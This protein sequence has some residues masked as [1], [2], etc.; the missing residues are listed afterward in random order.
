MRWLYLFEAVCGLIAIYFALPFVTVIIM[1]LTGSCHELHE[2]YYYQVA[3][4]E[5]IISVSSIFKSDSRNVMVNITSRPIWQNEGFE[6]VKTKKTLGMTYSLDNDSV[7]IDKDKEQ[8]FLKVPQR[9]RFVTGYSLNN[10]GC[11][12]I[13]GNNIY[14]SGL[15]E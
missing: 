11:P 7:Y 6:I 3:T 12:L 13:E 9:V 10:N 4:S 15:Y 8:Y 2:K 14:S 5:G 1:L